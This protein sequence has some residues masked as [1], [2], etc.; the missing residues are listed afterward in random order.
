M[1]VER[2][3]HLNPAGTVVNLM[4]QAPKEVNIVPGAMPPVEYKRPDEPANAALR[5][6][7]HR[8][9]DGE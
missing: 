9:T 5:K 2:R 7:R 6:G 4:E 3:N 1:F 8:I